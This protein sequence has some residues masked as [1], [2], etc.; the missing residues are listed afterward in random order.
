[1]A[2]ALTPTRDETPVRVSVND[3]SARGSTTTPRALELDI[4]TLDTGTYV[5]QLEIELAGG[6]TVRT[7][8]RVS[9][10]R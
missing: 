9:I 3:Q 4:S 10:I 6:L 7:E 5:V 2:G 8:R 1:M